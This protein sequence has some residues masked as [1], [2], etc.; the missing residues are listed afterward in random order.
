MKKLNKEPYVNDAI[1]S[2]RTTTAVSPSSKINAMKIRRQA[3]IPLIS[4]DLK[5]VTFVFI[6]SK[7]VEEASELMD[8]LKVD[9]A[10]ERTPA[11]NIPLIPIGK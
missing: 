8:E 2:P 1:L 5:R 7:I 9:I 6:Q 11:S 3:Q 10:A 4:I